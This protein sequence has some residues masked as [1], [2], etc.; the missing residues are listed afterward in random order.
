MASKQFIDVELNARRRG[1]K[2]VS[3]CGEIELIEL[4]CFHKFSGD[5]AD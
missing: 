2:T 4:I 3:G 5:G 1:Q